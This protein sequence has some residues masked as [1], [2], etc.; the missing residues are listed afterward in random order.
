MLNGVIAGHIHVGCD[1]SIQAP[2]I[3][4]C[5]IWMRVRQSQG[6]LIKS[7]QIVLH[8]HGSCHCQELAH[9]SC[10][11]FAQFNQAHTDGN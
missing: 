3:V 11:C 7:A 8:C 1:A 10:K 2:S 5:C 6:E 9:A 4:L